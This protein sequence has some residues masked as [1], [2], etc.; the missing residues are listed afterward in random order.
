MLSREPEDSA[1]EVHEL[2]KRYEA[3]QSAVDGLSFNVKVGEFFVIMGPSGSGKTTLLKC[4]AGL[5]II[6][7]TAENLY[8]RMC[9]LEAMNRLISI[10]KIFI[11]CPGN[12]SGHFF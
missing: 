2:S 12:V 5:M 8:L 1:L 9:R 6:V 10:H 4:I 7:K 11:L 3:G